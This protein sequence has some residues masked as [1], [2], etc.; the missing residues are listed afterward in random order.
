M[1]TIRLLYSSAAAVGMTY[2][3]LAE[4]MAQAQDRNSAH[5][6]T[7]MLCYGSGRFLQALEG[8]RTAVNALYHRIATDKR[9]R[10][11]QL[12]S[13]EEIAARDFPEW[14]MKVVNWEDGDT[15]RRRALLAADAGTSLFDP[16]TMTNGQA[17]AF[18]RH[19][20]DLERE[21]AGD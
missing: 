8:D 4:L 19:L 7:G 11:C 20:A 14:S 1:L 5:G 2:G 13:V 15:T 6:I 3:A 10:A 9:H 17:T 12:I 18:L 21:L 16:G